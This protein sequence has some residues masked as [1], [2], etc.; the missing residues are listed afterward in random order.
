MDIKTLRETINSIDDEMIRLF[1]RRMET[2]QKIAE[3]KKENALPI[4]DRTRER[5]VLHRLTGNVPEELA[6]YTK[7]LYKGIF[8]LSKTHQLSVLAKESPLAKKI[9]TALERTPDQFPAHATI[10][11]QGTEG[12]YSQ[13]ACDRMFSCPS[14]LYVDSFGAVFRAVDSGLCQY[15]ILPVENST[16]GSVTAV[17][18]LM[19]KYKF[20]II[21]STKLFINHALLA[22][23]ATALRD[24]KEIFSHEQALNQCSDYISKLPGVKVTVCKNTAIAARDL[25]ASGRTDAAVI[26]SSDCAEIYN[27]SVLDTGISNTENNYTRFICISKNLEIYPGANHTSLMVRLPHKPGTLH[28]V[29]SRFNALDINLTK[30]ESRPIVGANFEFMF[31]FDIEASVYSPQFTDLL[32]QLEYELPELTYLGS[33]HES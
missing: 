16:A 7:A 15:G 4:F 23:R 13:C 1:C 12:A 20:H 33:Y 8:E 5:E 22:P 30:L 18:E 26:C 2:A 6:P 17:Y 31:Y 14:I 28:A 27:L 9:A 24:V 29:L 32:S 11:C 3:Y 10:A 25:A 19:Q 21:K